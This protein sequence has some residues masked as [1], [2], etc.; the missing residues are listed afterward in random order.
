MLIYENMKERGMQWK[1]IFG[2]LIV[3]EQ[4]KWCVS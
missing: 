3:W 1:L 4:E 2:I